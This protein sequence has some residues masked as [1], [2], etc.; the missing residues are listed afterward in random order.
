MI[1]LTKQQTGNPGI[2]EFSEFLS[3]QAIE[4][5]LDLF[6]LYSQMDQIRGRTTFNCSLIAA[7]PKIEKAYENTMQGLRSIVSMLRETLIQNGF[8]L[9]RDE[10]T[11]EMEWIKSEVKSEVS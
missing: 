9:I 7:D 11:G 2:P 8:Q 3:E 10:K 5:H 6:W 4:S 1:K